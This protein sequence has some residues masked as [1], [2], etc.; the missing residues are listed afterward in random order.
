MKTEELKALGLNDEQIKQV[1]ALRGKAV[2]GI[3][4][5]RDAQKAAREK[6]EAEQQA[7]KAHNDSI[8]SKLDDI[9]Q[10][11]HAAAT[12]EPPDFQQQLDDLKKQLEQSEQQRATLQFEGQLK[13]ALGAYKPKNAQRLMQIIDKTQIQQDEKG[14]SGLEE[15]MAQLKESDP[16]LFEEDAPPKGGTHIQGDAG[17]SKMDMSQ[18]IRQAAGR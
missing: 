14:L 12:Q 9:N 11:L 1:M 18:A 16:Y 3:E 2:A 8:Q 7:L 15:Q 6:A 13:E 4:Q 5:E 10:K 17:G